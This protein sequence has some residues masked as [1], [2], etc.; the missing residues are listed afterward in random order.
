MPSAHG[1]TASGEPAYGLKTPRET[2]HRSIASVF[3]TLDHQ[4]GGAAPKTAEF[5]ENSPN[6]KRS[7]ILLENQCRGGLT[8]FSSELNYLRHDYRVPILIVGLEF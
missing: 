2:N 3:N 7:R 5:R 8:S 4:P 1:S 6:A